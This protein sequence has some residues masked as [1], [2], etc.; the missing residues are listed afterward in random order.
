MKTA[1]HKTVAPASGNRQMQPFFKMGGDGMFSAE[2]APFFTAS[3]TVIQAKLSVGQPDDK[4]EQEADATADRVVQAKCKE[5]AEEKK[6]LLTKAVN[7]PDPLEYYG[8]LVLGILGTSTGSVPREE[9]PVQKKGLDGYSDGPDFFDASLSAEMNLGGHALSPDVQADMQDSFGADFSKVRI[10][11]DSRSRD[12]N[13]E[14][15]AK[16]FTHKNHIFFNENQYDPGSVGG[17]HLL[18]HELTHTLQQ[19]GSKPATIQRKIGDGHDFPVASRFSG[20][21]ILEDVFDNRKVVDRRSNNNGAHV[22]L[23]QQVLVA[24]GYLLPTF[25]ADGRFGDETERAVRAFQQDVGLA[26]D[27]RVGFRTV[28]FLDRRDRNIEVAPPARPVLANTPFNTNNAI[29]QPGAPPTNALAGC[30]YGLTFP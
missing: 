30:V 3:Q 15:Q 13:E 8:N 11:H 6:G 28:D 18:A 17:K 2:Q 16:A 14:V 1:E 5:C 24:R 22:T 9:E 7:G 25:G 29:V 20:N 19:G 26:V 23:V 21:V 12:L 27:G 4:Y 10:H